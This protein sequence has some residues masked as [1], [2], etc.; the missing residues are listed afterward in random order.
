M[1][2]TL[3]MCVFKVKCSLAL[4]GREKLKVDCIGGCTVHTSLGPALIRSAAVLLTQ[5]PGLSCRRSDTDQPT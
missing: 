2:E 4:S 1:Y 5:Y 3:C